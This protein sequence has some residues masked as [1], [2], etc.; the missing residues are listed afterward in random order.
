VQKRFDRRGLTLTEIMAVIGIIVV[1]LAILLPGLSTV[2]RSGE[3]AASQSNL[4]QIHVYMTGYST[5][6]REFI[7]PSSFDY[8]EARFPGNVRENSPRSASPNM[9]PVD[10]GNFPVG[11]DQHVGSWADILWAYSDQG[12]ILDVVVPGSV[13]DIYNYRFDS[14]DHFVYDQ[15][16]EYETVF[17]SKA[18]NTRAVGG[19]AATPFGT[20]TLASEKGQPGYFAANDFFRVDAGS[21]NWYST[22]QIR[23]PTLSVYM[24]DSF[25]GET[26][27]PNEI[28][29]GDP[30]ESILPQVDFR[31]IGDA[32]LFLTLD[33]A[34]KTEPVF[35]GLEEVEDRNYRIHDLDQRTEPDHDHEG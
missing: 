5:D 9:G 18:T 20:G 26:I 14:P 32:A 28:G 11:E 12:A 34:I 8:R 24:V 2:R 33:G 13:G 19:N 31:Y 22:A 3:Q 30:T 25:A 7:V 29:W 16:P 1:L 10:G 35:Y 21:N 4:R 23:F 15:I 6:N 17:R 27:V